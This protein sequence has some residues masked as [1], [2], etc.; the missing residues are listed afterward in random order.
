MTVD[1][2]RSADPEL[3]LPHPGTAERATVLIP[4]LEID[5]A[6]HLLD[7]GPVATLPAALPEADRSRVRL[8]SDLTLRA[9]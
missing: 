9:L 7:R 8:R 5:P 4:W 2:V 3:L 6:A 1:Q